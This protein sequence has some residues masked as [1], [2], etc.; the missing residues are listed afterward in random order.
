MRVKMTDGVIEFPQKKDPQKRLPMSA[1]DVTLIGF[2]TVDD[3][4]LWID[5]KASIAQIISFIAQNKIK[6]YESKK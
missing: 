5:D 1:K 3:R 4:D 2:L 6:I